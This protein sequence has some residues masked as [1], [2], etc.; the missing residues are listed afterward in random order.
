MRGLFNT[1]D[2]KDGFDGGRDALNGIME[3]S[4][5]VMVL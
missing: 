1:G 3:V 4:S 5:H 2:G